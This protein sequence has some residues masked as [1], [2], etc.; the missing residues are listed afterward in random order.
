ML[1]DRATSEFVVLPDANSIETCLVNVR[2][3]DVFVIVLSQ[4]YG[5][6][7]AKADFDDVSAT[8]LEYREAK[9]LKK[10]IRM[11]VR[12]RLE[13]DYT[14]WKRNKRRDVSLPWIT[15][16]NSAILSL[17][18]EHRQ[19]ISYGKGSNWV[20]VFRDALDLKDMV[21]KDLKAVSG[22][23]MVRRMMES[24]TAAILIPRGY[25]IRT[26]G[27]AT[28]VPLETTVTNVGLGAAINV[29]VDCSDSLE[30]SGVRSP[31]LM[32]GEEL[33]ISYS[34]GVAE[35][36]GDPGHLDYVVRCC[37]TTVEG[38]SVAD[39][40]RIQ[41][42]VRYED[43]R[44]SAVVAIGFP[45]WY[46]SGAP[47]ITYQGKRYLGASPLALGLEPQPPV[48]SSRCHRDD[49]VRSIPSRRENA[50]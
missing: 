33:S 22:E 23:A 41:L 36:D 47:R 37:Y 1:S 49:P 18:H 46:V 24:G 10:P 12:D 20:S 5:P 9:R 28:E 27:G 40:T 29:L 19:L 35:A 26:G 13:S 42:D 17:L 7:L 21:A 39:E 14:I 44:Q 31:S 34:L 48:A 50:P 38:H 11:Y 25:Q 32:P 8:H 15:P 43:P 45:D 2:E 4:R 3:C 6:S 30:P 16:G